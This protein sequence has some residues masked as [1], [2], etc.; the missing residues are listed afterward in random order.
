MRYG[1][2]IVV[3]PHGSLPFFSPK[4][5]PRDDAIYVLRDL[6]SQSLLPVTEVYEYTSVIEHTRHRQD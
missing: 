5:P 6:I 4:L 2:L 1:I 3:E